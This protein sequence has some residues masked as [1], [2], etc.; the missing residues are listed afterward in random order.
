MYIWLY[1]NPNSRNIQLNTAKPTFNKKAQLFLAGMY[2]QP[3]KIM[4][5]V[6]F[7][8]HFGFS[9]RPGKCVKREL[10]IDEYE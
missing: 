5:Y 4:S 3:F 10:M 9:I 6:T 7:K 2:Q 1:R 8:M